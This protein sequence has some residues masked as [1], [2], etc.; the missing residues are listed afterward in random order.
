MDMCLDLLQF[1]EGE[2]FQSAAVRRVSTAVKCFVGCVLI[3]FAANGSALAQPSTRPQPSTSTVLISQAA[4]ASL[5]TTDRFST[6]ADTKLL[7]Q[8]IL[9]RAPDAYYALEELKIVVERN[10]QAEV[11][12]NAGVKRS[13][14]VFN[15]DVFLLTS[16]I[17]LNRQQN[18]TEYLRVN[19]YG[20]PR[21]FS[22]L[23]F[24]ESEKYIEKARKLARFSSL[25][26]VKIVIDENIISRKKQENCIV[27]TNSRMAS[28][29]LNEP[30]LLAQNVA[31]YISVRCKNEV[32]VFTWLQVWPSSGA[33]VVQLDRANATVIE[34]TDFSKDSEAVTTNISKNTQDA[35]K[36]TLSL[37]TSFNHQ[38][39]SS[40]SKFHRNF[41]LKPGKFV[42]AGFAFSGSSATA[43][44]DMAQLFSNGN[45][46]V[47][48]VHERIKHDL[49]R[50]SLLKMVF[51]DEK[52][53][54]YPWS[55]S[56]AQEE[57]SLIQ[58]FTSLGLSIAKLVC[59]SNTCRHS[60]VDSNVFAGGLF[61]VGVR[62]LFGR[63][64]GLG[65]DFETRVRLEG[66]PAGMGAQAEAHIGLFGSF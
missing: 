24:T 10:R 63:G 40:N 47:N 7:Y 41:G 17:Y 27:T 16:G 37:R 31:A 2:G 45:V 35:Q 36:Y 42:A 5:G 20:M 46:Q 14:D 23:G 59:R 21:L 64:A 22:E 66:S 26:S 61:G 50:F 43:E 1:S 44:F 32:A 33:T 19:A 6:L 11:L 13:E 15:I 53:D 56:S 55:S 60:R 62:S 57:P 52:A 30:I 34:L 38:F 65:L 18:I 29:K 28:F 8:K 9:G 3:V 51:P 48:G 58:P 49:I 39:Y 12:E 25:G 54:L 4:P